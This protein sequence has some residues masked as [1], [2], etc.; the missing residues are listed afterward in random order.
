MD[1]FIRLLVSTLCTFIISKFTIHCYDHIESGIITGPTVVF[2]VGY[3]L[4]LAKLKLTGDF[5][6]LNLLAYFLGTAIGSSFFI[7]CVALL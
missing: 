1:F 4:E 5:D 3:S 6:S 2:F 7:C